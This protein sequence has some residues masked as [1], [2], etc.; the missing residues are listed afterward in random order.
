MAIVKS[1]IVPKNF[2]AAFEV[3]KGQQLPIAATFIA[4]GVRNSRCHPSYPPAAMNCLK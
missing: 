4:R 1:E 2:G 3:K